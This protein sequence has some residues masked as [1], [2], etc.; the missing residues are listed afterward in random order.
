MS[1]QLLAAI[2]QPVS[3]KRTMSCIQGTGDSMS[4]LLKVIW[5]VAGLFMVSLALAAAST[6]VVYYSQI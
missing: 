6:N 2:L 4:L 1:Y 3:D 5:M